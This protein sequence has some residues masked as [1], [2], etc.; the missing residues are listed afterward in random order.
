MQCNSFDPIT[1][2]AAPTCYVCSRH[3]RCKKEAAAGATNTDNGKTGNRSAGHIPMLTVPE[4][5]GGC[6]HEN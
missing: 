3:G 2:S 5:P 4:T 1:F 6:K